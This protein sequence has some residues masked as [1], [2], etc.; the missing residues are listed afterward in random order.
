M[1]TNVVARVKRWMA[2]RGPKQVIVAPPKRVVEHD[3]SNHVSRNKYA[4]LTFKDQGER[5][6][7]RRRRPTGARHEDLERR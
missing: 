3:H 1:F 6:K 2:T 4:K 7:A 5:E